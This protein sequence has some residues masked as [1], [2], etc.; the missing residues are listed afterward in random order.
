MLESFV[1]LGQ[2]MISLMTP[3]GLGI[4]FIGCVVGIF[5]GAVPGLSAFMAVALFVPVTYGLEAAQGFRLLVG[6]YVGG[7]TGGLIAA[8]LLNIPGTPSSIATCFDGSPL[9]K[10]GQAGRAIGIGV[11]ASTI[12]GLISYTIMTFMAPSLARF[13]LK[14][15]AYEFFAVTVFALTMVL[16]MASGNMLKGLLATF[17]GL[18]L[19]TVGRAPVT[20]TE[21]YTF[22]TRLLSNGFALIVVLLGVFAIKEVLAT[23]EEVRKKEHIEKVEFERVKGFGLS[24]K[25]AWSMKW[26]F[27]RSA[28][29]GTGIGILP[30]VGASVAG[31]V[32]YVAAKRCSKHPEEFGHGCID[33]IVASETSNNA[34]V[35]GAFIPLLAL[36]IPG[37][38]ITAMILGAFMIHGLNPGPLLFTTSGNLVYGIFAACIVATIM[39]AFIELGGVRLFVKLMDVPKH[40]LMPVILVMCVIGAMASNNSI[41]DVYCLLIFGVIGYFLYKF[42]LPVGCFVLA[43]ILGGYMEDYLI[44]ALM[45]TTSIVPFFTRPISC[46]FLIT[47]LAFLTYSI[48]REVKLYKRKSS[49]L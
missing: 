17:I 7:T 21:R 49:T 26:E 16:V 9:A 24:V 32:S 42:N 48:V 2:A 45:Y 38:S 23:A 13:S 31:M 15:S 5:F 39:V 29:I 27:L 34:V 40:I 11:L 12:G 18:M 20:T 36:G 1:N 22:G 3:L 41:F 43:Y 46:V 30:G 33:G 35:G 10:K 25:E 8:I 14:F 4:L 37:D 28:L 19:A 6:L 44:K 47:A